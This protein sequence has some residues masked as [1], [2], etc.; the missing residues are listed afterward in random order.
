MDEFLQA[1]RET[2]KA[3]WEN[4]GVEPRAWYFGSSVGSFRIWPAR[5]GDDCGQY[6]PR[7]RP[8][9]V[10]ASSGPKNVIMVLDTSG[11][12]LGLR[13]DLLKQAA[14]RVVDTLT[15][16]DRIAIVPFATVAGP[17]IVDQ[18]GNMF[19]ATRENK[20]L[21]K[22]AIDKLEAIGKTNIYDAFT[23]TFDV[24]EQ[25]A[26]DEFTVNCNTAIL[27]LTD[28]ELDATNATTTDVLALVRE[29]TLR[30]RQVLTKPVVLFTF[31]VSESQQVHELPSKLACSTE[32]GLWSKVTSDE[33]I[34][35][36]LSSYYRLF[37]LRLG[38][39]QNEEFA[40]WVEP[41]AFATG[42]VLGTTVSVPV[43]DRTKNPNLFLGVA[44][45]DISI[46][47]LDSALG[48][49]ATTPG[50][51]SAE[52][53]ERVS[54]VAYATAANCP[55]LD[56]GLCALESVRRQGLAGDEALCTNNC[57][58]EDFVQ[59]EE[60]LCPFV[61]DY[62]SDLWVST[63]ND[64]VPFVGRAC[65]II[66]ENAPSDEC[67]AQLDTSRLGEG[68]S[69]AF[70]IGAI[71]GI[72]V[73]VLIVLG[74]VVWWCLTPVDDDDEPEPPKIVPAS[75]DAVVKEQEKSATGV[76]GGSD[77]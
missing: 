29:R 10:A 41:Y 50:M 67:P 64:G 63:A 77:P 47:A 49:T 16:S 11:S 56:L 12:M 26:Q 59:V 3:Y 18:N 30:A 27:F 13:M 43:Y 31:S 15:V 54:R 9:Y 34:V 74:G 62:P 1:K 72:V 53:I 65:C 75:K 52:S 48:I 4:I 66:G 45:V 68:S 39:D 71:V 42:D 17:P 28:G 2:D 22:E 69:S 38:E 5:P 21:L 58:L 24:L 36:S 25:T 14:K 7:V 19:I 33:E 8:W 37:A 35:N 40:A 55:V 20:E 32:Y 61:T 46:T 51:G 73:G 44:A 60:E 6:D 70:P 57:T 76:G 23:Q